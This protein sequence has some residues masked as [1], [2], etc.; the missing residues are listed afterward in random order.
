[1]KRIVV[2]GGGTGTYTVLT[3]ILGG[4]E[5]AFRKASRILNIKCRLYN[6]GSQRFI[7]KFTRQYYC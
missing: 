5:A 3:E 1:M 2:I 6:N 7:Y 4:E